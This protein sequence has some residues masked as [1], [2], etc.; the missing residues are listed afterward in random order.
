MLLVMLQFHGIIACSNTSK[1]NLI[2][3]TS[4]YSIPAL[5]QV[6][7]WTAAAYAGSVHEPGSLCRGG[8][9]AQASLHSLIASLLLTQHD[10]NY[11]FNP[12]Q[13]GIL[14]L[15]AHLFLSCHSLTPRATE[16]L[17]TRQRDG[18]SE[19]DYKKYMTLEKDCHS[20]QLFSDYAIIIIMRQ[21]FTTTH[22]LTVE[23]AY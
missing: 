7:D 17:Y 21:R 4:C 8:F 19:R 14:Q 20:S 5:T 13:D 15:P 1:P 9:P 2:C 23:H 12:I 3:K 6:F 16:C 22:Y 18:V 11:A 10:Q